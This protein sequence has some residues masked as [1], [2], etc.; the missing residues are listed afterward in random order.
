MNPTLLR[1]P[2]HEVSNLAAL[3]YSLA[4]WYQA[5]STPGSHRPLLSPSSP[6]PITGLPTVAFLTDPTRLIA[7]P[8]LGAAVRP[9]SSVVACL[10]EHWRTQAETSPLNN[11]IVRRR[12]ATPR[13]VLLSYPGTRVTTPG[14][15][16]GPHA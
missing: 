1:L 16:G 4:D 13:G 11:Y 7:N 15:R 10:A 12:A 3:P 8:G 14:P 6:D 2:Y 5:T 9:D